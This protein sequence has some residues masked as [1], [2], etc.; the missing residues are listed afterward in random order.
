[1]L[2]PEIA[3]DETQ[4]FRFTEYSL[5]RICGQSQHEVRQLISGPTVF[6]CNECAHACMDIIRNNKGNGRRRR[7]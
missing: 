7:S 1:L 5:L 4:R 2:R 3:N 6:I